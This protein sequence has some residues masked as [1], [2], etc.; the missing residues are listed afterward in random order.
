MLDALLAKFPALASAMSFE[1]LE[2]WRQWLDAYA[3]NVDVDAALAR[4]EKAYRTREH[5]TEL[6]IASSDFRAEQ[7]RIE[8]GFRPIDKEAPRATLDPP[9]VLAPDVSRVPAWNAVPETRFR[10]WA[11]EHFASKPVV[12]QLT[13]QA[14]IYSALQA[15]QDPSVMTRHPHINVLW[16]GRQIE[17]TGGAVVFADLLKIP[18]FGDAYSDQVTNGPEVRAL[19]DGIDKLQSHLNQM[20]A[21]H[22]ELSDKNRGA[23][24]GGGWTGWVKK[25]VRGG[26][27]HA[28]E[29]LGAPSAMEMAVAHVRAQTHPDDTDAQAELAWL[30]ARSGSYPKLLGPNS[31]WAK[32]E[33]QLDAAQRFFQDGQIELAAG[34]LQEAEQSVAVAT[35]RFAGYEARVMGGAGIAVKWLER[36]KTAGKIASA[37]TGVTGVLRA[38]A[39]S[40]GYTATQEGL[41]EASVSFVDPEHK[42]DYGK[43]A[44]MAA[45]DGLASLFG[46]LTQGAFT[47][48]LKAR[49][50]GTLIKDWQLSATTAEKVLSV[51]GATTASFYNVPAK[52]VLDRIIDGK[53][54]PESLSD[55]CDMVVKEAVTSG[56][57]DIAGSIVAATG[58]IPDEAAKPTEGTPEPAAGEA[59]GTKAAAEPETVKAEPSAEQKIER[60]LAGGE[61]VGAV[62]AAKGPAAAPGTGGAALGP[63]SAEAAQLAAQLHPIR[64]QWQAL[65]DPLVRASRL[66]DEIYPAL[67]HT[68]MPEPTGVEVRDIIGARF[69]GEMW[70]VR[71][72]LKVLEKETIS[73]DEF[74]EV[75]GLLRH[76]LEHGLDWFRMARQQAAATG[77]NATQLARR[78]FIPQEIAE[79]AIAANQGQRAAEDMSPGSAVATETAA[80]YENVYGAHAQQRNQILGELDASWNRIDQARANL[81]SARQNSTPGSPLYQAAEQELA[82]AITANAPIEDAYHQ[83]PE[84]VAAYKAGG[85]LTA[86][87]QRQH[88]RLERSRL[89]EDE[90]FARLLPLAEQA[91]A[92][93]ET[94]GQTLAVGEQRALDKA[95]T[96][97]H[98]AAAHVK[99]LEHLM[100]LGQ[101]PGKP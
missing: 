36:V 81:A 34:A 15:Q 95:Y 87:M 61:P 67:A 3:H 11:Q 66:V 19:R 92:V 18:E 1:A 32:G 65:G 10:A 94:P 78:L 39:F 55:V 51:G 46:G 75:C 21:R 72:E 6:Y 82:D 9:K 35:T 58:H 24:Y 63:V 98:E 80:K 90:A 2:G 74:A 14:E 85:E 31:I 89:A 91:K 16:G 83:F 52:I 69:N 12:A 4:H 56:A 50:A 30:E 68:G 28:S 71:I 97:W 5:Y 8:R 13:D 79:A 88:A 7:A 20:I 62:P 96:E 93:H 57:M 26:V 27:R 45:I 41:E 42:A 23:E 29:A 25:K 38:A 17:T 37:F 33:Q 48:A 73:P 44:R 60:A 84:E 100:G 70:S 77:E 49:F 22:R 40:A 76:E 86:A 64:E 59:S 43:V 47:D 101:A 54:M 53:A 99:K